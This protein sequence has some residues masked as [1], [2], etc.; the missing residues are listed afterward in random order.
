MQLQQH[1]HS[2]YCKRNNTCRFKFPHPPTDKTLIAEEKCEDPQEYA[3]TLNKVRKVLTEG[4]CDNTNIDDVLTKA[5]VTRSD[6]VEA[7]TVSANGFVVVLKRKP[8][9]NNYNPHVLLAWQANLDIQ[10]VLNAYAC[11][12]Y[13]ASYIMKTDRA[14]SELLRRVATETRTGTSDEKSRLCFSYTSRGQCPRGC[15]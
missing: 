4:D 3:Q 7:L 13:I 14:M 11:V 9:I 6:Y 8:N 15:I 10:Y 12:M 1:K 5:N 2:S